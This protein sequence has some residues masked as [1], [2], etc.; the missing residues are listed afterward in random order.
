MMVAVI[1]IVEEYPKKLVL[2]DSSI[3]FARPMAPGDLESLTDFFSKIPKEDMFIYRNDVTNISA[4]ESWFTDETYKKIFQLIVEADGE[5]VGKGTLH[6]EGPY[7]SRAVEMKLLVR[8]DYRNKGLGGQIFNIL[9]YEGFKTNFHK[10]IIKYRP[11]S[12]SLTKILNHY[13]FKPETLLSSYI[14]DEDTEEKQQ[15]NIASFNLENWSRRF[16]VYSSMN[17]TEIPSH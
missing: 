17:K 16:E 8:P 15:I 10:I 7:H 12:G 2:N 1:C 6:T 13:G 9:L 3:V 5:I 4:L 14:V 11:E